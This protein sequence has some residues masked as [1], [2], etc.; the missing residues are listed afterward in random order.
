LKNGQAQQ[1]GKEG[2]EGGKAEGCAKDAQEA[3][4]PRWRISA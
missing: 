3:C 2:Q 1:K 4:S